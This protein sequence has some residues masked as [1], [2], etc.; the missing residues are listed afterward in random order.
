MPFLDRLQH[1]AALQPDANAV[2]IGAERLS[3]AEL[4]DRATMRARELVAESSGGPTVLCRPNGL[5]FVVDFVAAVAGTGSVA[6]LDP[7]WPALQRST[8]ERM[9]RD[10][11]TSSPPDTPPA[12]ADLRDGPPDSL[13]LY[14]FTSGTTALPKAF[15]RSRDSWQRAFSAS[16]A[17]F[18]LGADDR[19]LA[20]GPL[21]ASLTLYALAE[22]LSAGAAFHTLPH[23]DVGDALDSVAHAAVT[24]IVAVPTALRLLGERGLSNAVDGSALTGIVSAG[25]R[26]DGATL[27]RVRTWAP[28]ATVF[29]YYGAAELSFVTARRLDPGEHRTASPTAVGRPF[30]GVEVRVLDDAG[31][32]SAPG[33]TGTICVRSRLVGAGYAWGDDGSA[34]ARVAGDHGGEWCTV[35][36]QGH[37]DEAGELHFAGR[38]ADMIV[39]SGHNVYPQEV[40]ATLL[41]GLGVSPGSAVAQVVVT[42]VADA[43]RGTL[44][45]AAVLEEGSPDA[46]ALTRSDLR[47]AAADLAAPKRPRGYYRLSELPLTGA[48]KISRRLLAAWIT[49][50]DPRVDRLV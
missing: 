14:G 44:L 34:F 8:V 42:G 26:L 21:S 40:E 32:A 39:T 29:D 48:G 30:P 16:N 28:K 10:A 31:Q 43:R 25:A 19:V 4:R 11:A 5:D 2:T 3:Y 50:G 35:G 17:W 18:D 37:L 12:P 20:P 15:T 13:F 9:L 6:V 23:F 27:A 33:V 22:T 45:V 24:R 1:W 49:E 7:G 38:R 47:T 46:P 36:D 41:S